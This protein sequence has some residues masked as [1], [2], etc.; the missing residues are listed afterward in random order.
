MYV[1]AGK[2]IYRVR[3]KVA[4]AA[5]KLSK[6]LEESDNMSEWNDTLT[7]FKILK[8]CVSGRMPEA[9]RL[10]EGGPTRTREMKRV[11]GGSL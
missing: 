3:A 10:R 11:V 4:I 5:E 7:E 1:F 2:K 6:K 8:V 9:C